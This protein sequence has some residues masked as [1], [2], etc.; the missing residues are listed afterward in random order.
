MQESPSPRAARTRGTALLCGNTGAF[1][2]L[3]PLGLTA[4]ALA[5]DMGFQL[6]PFSRETPVCPERPQSTQR[7]A[8]L[9]GEMPIS[10][11]AHIKPVTQCIKLERRPFVWSPPIQCPGCPAAQGPDTPSGGPRASQGS[12][13]LPRARLPRGLMVPPPPPS[14]LTVKRGT[15]LRP[16]PPSAFLSPKH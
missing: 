9:P 8:S 13:S 3:Q 5:L 10:L 14:S 2:L 6:A 7:G 16:T 15:E 1:C 11:P 12:V 4:A